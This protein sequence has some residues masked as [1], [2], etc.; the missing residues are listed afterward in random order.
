VLW[1]ANLTSEP[2]KAKV[3]GFTGAASA[4]ALDLSS[5]GK[6]LADPKLMSK[7]GKTVK[8]VGIVELGPYAVVRIDAA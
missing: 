8:K 2:K 1:L 5:Y 6:A 7:G 3:E 4:Q